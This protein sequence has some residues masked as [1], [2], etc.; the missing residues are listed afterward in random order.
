MG[1]TKQLNKVTSILFATFSP[2]NNN[3]RAATN[4]MI[5]P[6]YYYFRPRVKYLS[7][8][9]QPYPGSDRIVPNVENYKNGK[10]QKNIQTTSTSTLLMPFLKRA[11]KPGTHVS[12]KI[13]DLLSVIEAGIRLNRTYD[14]FI[15]LESVNAIGGIFLRRI[16]KVKCVVYY[17]SDYSPK[18]FN[19]NILNAIYLWLD[20]YCAERADFIWDV[21]QAMQPARI[22]AG[23]NVQKSAPVIYVPNA[24]F[25]EQ[26]DAI[27]F[28]KREKHSIVFMGTIGLENGPDLAIE[29]FAKV[30]K[31]VPTAKLHIIGGGGK[32]FEQ[33]LLEN[34]TKK[35]HM[36]KSVV[37]YGFISDVKKV[38][39]LIKHFQVALAPYK[40]IPGSIRLYGDATK[41]RQYLAA[42][43]PIITTQVPPL[44]KEAQ[45]NGAALIVE[46]NAESFANTILDLMKDTKKCEEM[47]K[48]ALDSA[49]RNTWE[50]TYGGAIKKMF[51]EL[52]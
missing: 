21:S 41:I 16:G 44:G 38:S 51:L 52:K 9:D 40:M 3:V 15:G 49:K 47:A 28:K 33:N 23:L 37:F 5:D 25:K 7:I 35:H 45:K 10:P 18:R 48:N 6:F 8:I 2:W 30:V 14:L 31:K 32:G 29:A 13:R 34:I 11:N 27:P 4:G 42:G 17:V 19:S 20:R 36:E 12:F 26:I 22:E 46:D 50:N 1:K 39:S 24:L 43:L